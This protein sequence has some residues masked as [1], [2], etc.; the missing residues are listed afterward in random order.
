MIPNQQFHCRPSMMH[1]VE[2]VV[3][4]LFERVTNNFYKNSNSLYEVCFQLVS[5]QGVLTETPIPSDSTP[6]LS[7][8]S[9]LQQ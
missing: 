2:V 6:L 4:Q 3:I 7:D 8:V 9:S 5:L 1:R